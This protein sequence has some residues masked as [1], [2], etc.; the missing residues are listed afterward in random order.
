MIKS[1]GVLDQNGILGYQSYF[2]G[3]WD[4]ASLKM[5]YWD[6]HL[7]FGILGYCSHKNL[8]ISFLKMGF[9]DI[10]HLKLGY[11]DIAPL[12]LGYLGYRDPL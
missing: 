5:G 6:I 1:R 7:K 10:S 8:N 11:W 4:I 3:Y 12:K 2:L 9:W